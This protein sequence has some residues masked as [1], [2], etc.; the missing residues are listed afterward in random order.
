MVSY[1]IY[2]CEGS[3]HLKGFCWKIKFQINQNLKIFLQQYLCIST[4]VYQYFCKNFFWSDYMAWSTG[5]QKTT[6]PW[7]LFLIAD[8]GSEASTLLEVSIHLL[9]KEGKKFLLERFWY[10]LKSRL[11]HNNNLLKC[12]KVKLDESY[13][14]SMHILMWWFNSVFL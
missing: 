12:C 8:W 3:I 14:V 13:F 1:D 4:F 10:T 7:V 11:L 5:N 2:S 9:I 6:L